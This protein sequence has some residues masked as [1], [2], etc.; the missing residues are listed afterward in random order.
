MSGILDG[1]V[2]LVTG[3]SSGIGRATAVAFGREGAKVVV[4]SRRA[5][6]SEETVDMIRAAGG[7][8]VRPR[9]HSCKCR[10]PGLDPY[11]DAR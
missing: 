7:A 4:A 10:V 6:E 8:G 5:P 3:G 9:G 1:K 11:T 2:A